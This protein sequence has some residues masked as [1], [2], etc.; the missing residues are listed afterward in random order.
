[1]AQ[2][3][4]LLTINQKDSL[5]GQLVSPDGYFNPERDINS[6]WFISQEE[7]ENS[8]FPEHDWI[9]DLVLTEYA[10]PYPVPVP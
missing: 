8:V 10:G 2:L 7:I 6:D 5:E 9:K 4:A 1:M 3:V